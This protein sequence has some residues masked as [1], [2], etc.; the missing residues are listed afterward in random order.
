MTQF[1]IIG[2]YLLITCPKCGAE[3]EEP[4]D[5]KTKDNLRKIKYKCPLCGQII[6][7]GGEL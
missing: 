6:K 7:S 4:M 5:K 2:N 3:I 1:Q